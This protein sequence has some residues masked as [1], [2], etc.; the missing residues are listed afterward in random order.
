[1]VDVFTT[2]PAERHELVFY[3]P[4]QVPEYAQ[5]YGQPPTP[6]E[7]QV[8]ARNLET[9]L[10]MLRQPGYLHPPYLRGLVRGITIPTCIVWGRQDRIMPLECGELYQQA[11]PSATLVII[12]RCGHRPYL[13]KPDEFVKVALDFLP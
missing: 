4:R 10:L 6:E 12:D 8:A 7:Q 13:E 2:T 1:V 5:I 9:A 3:D 11:I